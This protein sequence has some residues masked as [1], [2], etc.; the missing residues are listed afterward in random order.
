MRMNSKQ[1][2]PLAFVVSAFICIVG[3]ICAIHYKNPDIA[4]RAGALAVAWS[5]GIL[6]K[7]RDFAG[8]VDNLLRDLLPHIIRGMQEGGA[9]TA[10]LQARQ[11]KMLPQA[12]EKAA[13]SD[14]REQRTQNNYLAA[15][16]VLGT[17]TWGF[18]DKVAGWLI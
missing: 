5:F 2:Y 17:L 1:F 8:E 6:I 3:L 7:R 4:A 14:I 9:D 10:H 16:S 13:N 11:D 18:G 12:T 15:A